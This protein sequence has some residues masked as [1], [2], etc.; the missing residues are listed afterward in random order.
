M[1]IHMGYEFIE[2]QKSKI[3][4]YINEDCVNC[5]RR[6]VMTGDDG[7]RRCEKCFYCVDDEDFDFD[8]MDY[9]K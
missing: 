8:F 7:K 4:D 2:A 9:M 6:R 5:G 3:G 1:D